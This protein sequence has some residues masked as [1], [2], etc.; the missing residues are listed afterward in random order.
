MI[1]V[2]RKLTSSGFL[3][4]VGRLLSPGLRQYDYI[5]KQFCRSSY[6]RYIYSYFLVLGNITMMFRLLDFGEPGT[7][8]KS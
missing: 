5:F 8:G 4:F 6:F 1:L 2:F 7:I 3:A